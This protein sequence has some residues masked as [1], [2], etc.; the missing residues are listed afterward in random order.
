MK[1]YAVS[2]VKT[3]LNTYGRTFHS[4][5]EDVLYF[6]WSAST[7]ELTF[8]GTKLAVDLTADCAYEIEGM[9]MDPNAPRR[10]TWPVVAV[11][12]DDSPHPLHTFEI[13]EEKET[14]VVWE[15]ENS[16][17]HKIRLTKLTENNKTFLG[18][19]ALRL[20]GEILPTER[21]KRPRMEIV[22]DSITCGYGNLV[23]DPGRHFY[24]AEED[25]W[26][27]YGPTAARKLGMEFSC[28]CVS[29]ITAVA[30]QGW[31]IG[32]PMNQLYA[33]T[34]R[35]MQEKLGMKAES[36]DFKGNPNEYVVVNLGTNDC[37]GILFSQDQSELS[38]FPE[39]Y[40][41]FIL[42]IR[43]LNGPDTHIICALGNMNYYLYHEI[44]QVVE[45][46]RQ[47]TGDNRL[48][49]FRFKP[50]HPF[51]GLGAD[52]H[53]SMATHR[54]MSEELVSFIKSIEK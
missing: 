4:P 35:L 13:G 50:I 22:G 11:F 38:R 19:Q 24:S 2:E 16:E 33:Y 15:S 39:D 25:G 47:E 54:K 23:T 20:D 51:D 26:N 17:T 1:R 27:A 48:H 6:D 18:I 43:R 28:V 9:P 30:H 10:P 31:M 36:W 52:G 41:Q 34:D 37:F 40:A 7:V 53:P 32:Y 49:L 3:F 45:K 42:E 21:I 29:G 12:V 14:K 44:A 8:R 46:L 5:E